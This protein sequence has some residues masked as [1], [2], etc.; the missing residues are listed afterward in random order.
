MKAL[1]LAGGKGTRLRPLT[2]YTPKPIVP[3]VN[4]PFL[5]YQVEILRRAGVK[6]IVLSLNY[7]PNK[8]QHELG[9]GSE[10]G[11][12]LQYVTEPQPMGTAGAY[13]YASDDSDEATIVLNGDILTDLVVKTLIDDHM[14]SKADATICL[15][16]VEDPAAFGSVDTDKDRRVTGFRE[17]PK[18]EEISRDAENLINAGIYILDPKILDLIPK[19]TNCSFEYDV[20][21]RILEKQYRFR[22]FDLKDSYW[23]DIGTPEKYL[24]AH[25]DFL[26]GRV[27]RFHIEQK[28]ES[29]DIAT[30]AIV[31][32]ASVIGKDSIIKPSASVINS[33]IGKGVHVEERAVVK[34]SVIWAHSRISHSAEIT[35]AV[36]A[37]GCYVG[38]NAIMSKGTVLGDKS[39]LTDYTKV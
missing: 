13:R 16:A 22:G 31:D 10:Y 17:K 30:S 24:Q 20:F 32:S 28:S 11:V 27:R 34:D 33:V 14:N 8:I 5:L 38:K 9:D 1:I 25:G 2:V 19:D 36:I 3:V 6:D 26:A 21:P 7:Q 12:K 4:R 29:A 39:S 23:C 35:G 15:K 37:K 18:P